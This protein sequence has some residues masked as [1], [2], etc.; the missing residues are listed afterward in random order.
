MF[1]L[2]KLAYQQRP[3][4]EFGGKLTLEQHLAN[5]PQPTSQP[6]APA[7]H[8]DGAETRAAVR[9]P[10]RFEGEKPSSLNVSTR[11]QQ[12]EPSREESETQRPEEIQ[13]D[14]HALLELRVVNAILQGP[15]HE[16]I[17]QSLREGM[18]RNR[19]HQRPRMH[20]RPPHADGGE[21]GGDE[22][23]PAPIGRLLGRSRRLRGGHGRRVRFR[24]QI[25]TP[26]ADGRYSVPRRD[27]NAIVEC[28]RQS[29][30]LNSLGE[31]ARDEIVAEVGGL[32]SQH[33]VSS[34]LGGNFRGTLELLIQVSAFCIG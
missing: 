27:Q 23:N 3:V 21:E 1:E 31:E 5:R 29:P 18:D 30:A 26:N 6:P 22:M 33:L 28:L 7:P 8:G 16:E 24:P 12:L 9:Y 4:S 2:R 14:M 15:V 25:P 13:Q 10:A 20:S 34:A 11:V 32:V 19:S 17:D